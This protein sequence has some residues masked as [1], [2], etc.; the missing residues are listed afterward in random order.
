MFV[1]YL[2]ALSGFT[3]EL[4]GHE[5]FKVI[6]VNPY[7]YFISEGEDFVISIAVKDELTLPEARRLSLLIQDYLIKK[8][9]N[10][11]IQE[12]EEHIYSLFS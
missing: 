3:N 2:K 11:K 5:K 6:K 8:K 10:L 12:L 9:K 1:G 7:F 4:L